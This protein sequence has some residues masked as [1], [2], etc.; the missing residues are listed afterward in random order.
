M[1]LRCI[2][3]VQTLGLLLAVALSLPVQAQE[4]QGH[5]LVTAL[6]QGGYVMYV[7]HAN[8]ERDQI[9]QDPVDYHDRS[10]QR[11][12]SEEG[13]MQAQTLGKALHQLGIPF[14]PT[15]LT[16]PYCRCVET[17]RLAFGQAAPLAELAFAIKLP[18][19]EARQRG[20]YLDQ[21]LRTQPPAG[22]NNVIVAHTAN[23]K[24]AA[25]VWPKPEGVTVIFQPLPDGNYVLVNKLKVEEWIALAQQYGQENDAVS[26]TP[27]VLGAVSQAAVVSVVCQEEK[28]AEAQD[29]LAIPYL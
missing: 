23:L 7:R 16:S 24:E 14:A 13:R 18:A 20:L 3:V 5:D 2:R 10:T 22:S 27:D 6:R 8:T 12:L 4:L 9:D 25:H 19:D 26:V 29:V 11:N 17:A 1:F 15:P 21:L 28:H